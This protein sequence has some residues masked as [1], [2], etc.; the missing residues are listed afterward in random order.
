MEN[1]IQINRHH[2]PDPY[3]NGHDDRL[4]SA[5]DVDPVSAISL[6]QYGLVT[7][8]SFIF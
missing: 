3:R 4:T 6:P 8:F 7:S 2:E 1:R 5:Y